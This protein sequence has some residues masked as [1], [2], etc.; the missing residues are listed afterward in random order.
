MFQRQSI[1][2]AASV[3]RGSVESLESQLE[4]AMVRYF[5]G[6]ILFMYT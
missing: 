5:A 1:E 3:A 2:H 6:E 4:A